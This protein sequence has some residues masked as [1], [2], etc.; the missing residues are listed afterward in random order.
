GAPARALLARSRAAA[1]REGRGRRSFA[2]GARALRAEVHVP[3]GAEEA[4][5]PGWIEER[6]GARTARRGERDVR[7]FA[8]AH[9]GLHAGES[10]GEIEHDAVAGE[11]GVHQVYGD[12]LAGRGAELRREVVEVVDLDVD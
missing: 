1:S 9:T 7:V 5:R 3:G 2:L 11:V 8:C 4:H 10:G 12:L 6:V